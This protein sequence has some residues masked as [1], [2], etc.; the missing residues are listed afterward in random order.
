MAYINIITDP[1]KALTL[2]KGG[3]CACY[4]FNT[5]REYLHDEHWKHHDESSHDPKI[6]RWRFGEENRNKVN[7]T[8]LMVGETGSGKTT[9]LNTIINYMIGVKFENK[10]WFEITEEDSENQ[11]ISQTSAV[12][13]YEVHVETQQTSLTII[14]TPGYGDTRGVDHDKA[15]A[16]HLCDLI[17]SYEGIDRIDAVG[18]VVKSTQNRLS[19]VQRCINSVLSLFGKDIEDN[20]VILITHSDGLPPTGG[21]NAIK[22]AK[23][24]CATDV[25]GEPI[26]FLFNNRQC[27]PHKENQA[28]YYKHFWSLGEESTEGFF[29]FIQKVKGKSLKM[30]G[31][32]LKKRTQLEACLRDFT[33]NINKVSEEEKE[34]KK[35]N[36]I[37]RANK[38]KLDNNERFTFKTQEMKLKKVPIKDHFA[39][40]DEEAMCCD[41]CKKNC[42]FPGCTWVDSLYWCTVI[43]G[44][45]C[46]VCGCSYNKH[47]KE[48][49]LYMPVTEEDMKTNEDLKKEYQDVHG[50]N[51]DIQCKIDKELTE[52]RQ[53]MPQ[54]LENTYKAI[55]DL[56]KIA[57]H[58]EY[59]N[60]YVDFDILITKLSETNQHDKV[61]KL[62]EIND[63]VPASK[64]SKGFGGKV[65]L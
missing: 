26:H 37:V 28:K 14:D 35:I 31:N 59:L 62:K 64:V 19:D 56:D 2:T 60:T 40:C 63:R 7:K 49:K 44:G 23:I 11:F 41:V 9:L 52:K 33:A 10:V 34:L 61:Q 4:R 46:T 22:N 6:R 50:K 1:L 15:I 45:I 12:T 43:S 25:D 8:I 38:A 24:K 13:V 5:I 27:E 18:L 42:H 65:C 30:T 16:D 57:L 58:Q 32:V 39:L 36:D 17:E 51:V 53:Q 55:I 3:S 20:I 29:E 48:N 54:L 47:T 21:L